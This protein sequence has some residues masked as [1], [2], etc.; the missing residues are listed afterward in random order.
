MRIV[1]KLIQHSLSSEY[2]MPLIEGFITSTKKKTSKISAESEKN[3]QNR[4]F[5]SSS[6]HHRTAS[7]F[8]S[9]EILK[10]NLKSNYFV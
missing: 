2:K 6:F 10:T 1:I 3:D 4:Q 5:F 7:L 9:I 8:N